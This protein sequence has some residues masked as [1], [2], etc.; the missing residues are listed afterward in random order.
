MLQN[1][2]VL[3]NPQVSVPYDGSKKPAG[4]VFVE[5]ATSKT[6][7]LQGGNHNEHFGL[8][9]GNNS[10]ITVNGG[11]GFDSVEISSDLKNS[12]VH[13]GSDVE[14][15]WLPGSRSD[16]KNLS[17]RPPNGPETYINTKTGTQVK[18]DSN[19]TNLLIQGG[20]LY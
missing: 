7:K 9:S 1:I 2:R 17:H 4:K 5:D 10:N 19:K 16:Y 12:K 11:K 15:V 6:F 20:P 18:V 13:I 8:M 3:N 14:K